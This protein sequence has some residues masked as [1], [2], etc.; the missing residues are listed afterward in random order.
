MANLKHDG[1]LNKN[2]QGD[3]KLQVQVSGARGEGRNCPMAHG[4]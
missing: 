2:Y 4:P 1:R 3:H